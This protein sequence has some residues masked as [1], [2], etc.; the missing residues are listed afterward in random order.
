MVIAKMT[1]LETLMNKFL[2]INN[3]DLKEINSTEFL[4][5]NVEDII[6]EDI[7]D[8]QM[9]ANDISEEIDE[10]S[11][12][13]SEQNYPAYLAIVGLAFRLDEEDILKEQ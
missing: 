5:A 12:M 3:E 13:I 4:K 6:D 1:L 11:W 8:I 9:V 7:E 10:N 2:H